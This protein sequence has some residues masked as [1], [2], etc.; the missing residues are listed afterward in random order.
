MQQLEIQPG[1]GIGTVRFG[2]RP[3]E[4]IAALVNVNLGKSNWRGGNLNDCLLYRDI[5][6]AFDL[7][8]AH[9]PTPDARLNFIVVR[10]RNDVRLFGRKIDQWS[11]SELYDYLHCQGLLVTREPCGDLCVKSPYAGISFDESWNVNWVEIAP[12]FKPGARSNELSK[13]HQRCNNISSLLF[14][15]VKHWFS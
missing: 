13:P 15:W 11:R 1:V 3:A 6:F 10:P 12:Q 9:G 7:C 4:V 14:S 5:L 2:I 8:D